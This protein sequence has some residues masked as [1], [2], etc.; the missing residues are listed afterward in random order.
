MKDVLSLLQMHKTFWHS[1]FGQL[2][3]GNI[4][5]LYP[6][7]VNLPIITCGFLAKARDWD[8]V[9]IP[10][11]ITAAEQKKYSESLSVAPAR[12]WYYSVSSYSLPPTTT[13]YK[14]KATY[15]YKNSLYFST[16][17]LPRPL[18]PYNW[19]LTDPG[20]FL[21]TVQRVTGRIYSLQLNS[22]AK[23]QEF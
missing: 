12:P 22:A 19:V 17:D 8:I 21:F 4:H 13:L 23:I 18:K 14:W 6:Q 7:H 1:F 2:Q 5:T 3:F 16:P 9:S 15:L 20:Y 10:P 11:T